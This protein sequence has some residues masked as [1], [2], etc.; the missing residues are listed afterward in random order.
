MLE[1]GSS[2]GGRICTLTLGE[3]LLNNRLQ[4]N[5]DWIEKLKSI[6]IECGATWISEDHTFMIYLT[7]HYKLT[8]EPQYYQGSHVFG[9]DNSNF[10]HLESMKDYFMQYS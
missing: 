8:L 9:L 5:F 2:I 1:A 3:A 10:L 4:T 6:P 7:Q